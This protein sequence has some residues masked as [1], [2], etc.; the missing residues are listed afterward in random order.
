M[1]TRLN[2]FLRTPLVDDAGKGAKPDEE[3]MGIIGVVVVLEEE[4]TGGGTGVM[5]T[6]DSDSASDMIS[7]SSATF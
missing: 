6:S 4:A 3:G 2:S 5:R 7:S 1:G